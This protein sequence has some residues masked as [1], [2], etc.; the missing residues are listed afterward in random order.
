MAIMKCSAFVK[1][2]KDIATNYKTLYILCQFVHNFNT[3]KLFFTIK[4]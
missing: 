2:A 3:I 1:I 4:K